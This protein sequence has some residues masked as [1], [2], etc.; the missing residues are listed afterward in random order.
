MALGGLPGDAAVELLERELGRPLDREEQ[1]GPPHRRG[2]RRRAV[3]D[4]GGAAL[5]GEIGSELDELAGRMASGCTPDDL[6]AM[7]LKTL[8]DD[9]RTVLSV[10]TALG[11]ATLPANHIAELTGV[12]DAEAVIASLLKMGLIKANSPRYSVT[13]A[14]TLRR[15]VEHSDWHPRLRSHFTS[16][17]ERNGDRP[18][19]VME[20][21]RALI[22][23]LDRAAET[24]AWT[25]LLRLARGVEGSFFVTKQWGGWREVLEHQLTAAERLGDRS[26][27]GWAHHQLGSRALCLGDRGAALDHLTRALAIRESLGEGIAA[28]TTRH[29]LSLLA[30]ASRRPGD[31]VGGAA[32]V[33]AAAAPIAAVPLLVM[34]LGVVVGIIVAAGA[35]AV[36]TGNFGRAGS[37]STA[38]TESSALRP[39]PDR[40]DFGAVAAGTDVVRSVTLR[41]TGDEPVHIGSVAIAG[42]LGVFRVDGETCT[43]VAVLPG[44]GCRIDVR[45]SPPAPGPYRGEL[46]AD[47][48]AE[49]DVRVP[50]TGTTGNGGDSTP[51]PPLRAGIDPASLDFGAWP[52][53]GSPVVRSVAVVSTGQGEVR[54]ASLELDG[55]ERGFS[56]VRD[57]CT[58][59]S[60][61]PGG[62]CV[63]GV[64]FDPAQTGLRRGVLTVTLA[65]PGGRLSSSLTGT[66]TSAP[67]GAVVID[68]VAAR[69]L[70]CGSR[71]DMAVTG[72]DAG[73]PGVPL[74][75]SA[76]GLPRG[77]SL[78][79]TLPTRAGISRGVLAA[80]GRY[81]QVTLRAADEE[82]DSLTFPVDVVPATLELTWLQPLV[83]LTTGA[84]PTAVAVVR[85]TEGTGID[86]STVPMVFE[87]TNTTSRATTQVQT[88]PAPDGRVALQLQPSQLTPGLYSVRLRVDPSNPCYRMASAVPVALAVNADAL[89]A[90]LY[91]LSDLLSSTPL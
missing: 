25:D 48:G 29:N 75:F 87:V 62:R 38:A 30:G 3:A 61:P 74:T 2:G 9:E 21:R 84:P 63:V 39:D 11:G 57:G 71:V 72:S 18:D 83:D 67:D 43:T 28:A 14:P 60:L 10:L 76:S 32:T 88:T 7:L 86:L 52:I 77:L 65:P 91:A 51:P 79:Q 73:R 45:F 5:L 22:S 59:V 54:V 90:T 53:S 8:D 50:V 46:V 69:R 19:V 31:A 56:I 82:Q 15:V 44:E 20:E 66:G 40:L 68:P 33:V 42:E 64:A 4:P 58:G 26:A 34:I 49:G 80:P 85:Q 35:V 36:A 47:A 78:H 55:A 17:V 89:G 12:H 6:A 41:N 1:D 23:V 16:W 70:V 37:S 81:T 27:A 24:A 13:D